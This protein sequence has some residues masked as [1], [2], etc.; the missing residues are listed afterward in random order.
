MWCGWLYN[1]I[2]LLPTYTLVTYCG[3][4]NIQGNHWPYSICLL[5]FSIFPLLSRFRGW[6]SSCTRK[7]HYYKQH[8][9]KF[10]F[11]VTLPRN[12][13]G[14][15][16]KKRIAGRAEREKAHYTNRRTTAFYTECEFALIWIHNCF[17]FVLTTKSS[18]S[19][20]SRRIAIDLYCLRKCPFRKECKK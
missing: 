20:L 3:K 1:D 16:E 14:K 2:T 8:L 7:T 12:K 11:F 13:K 5:I 15:K 6:S 19:Q 18:T 17:F 9:T 10:T 4:L